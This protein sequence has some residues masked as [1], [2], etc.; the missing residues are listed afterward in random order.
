MTHICK[1]KRYLYIP[2]LCMFLFLTSCA[3]D[4]EEGW[5]Y[6]D[7]LVSADVEISEAVK[8]PEALPESECQDY[9]IMLYKDEVLQWEISL[10]E[11]KADPAN[12]Y[13]RVPAG[14]YL[15][16]VESC[17]AEEAEEGF[18][19]PRY[20]GEK[21][22]TVT[23]GR[24]TVETIVCS[25]VNAKV[26]LAYA[27]DFTQ[28]YMPW[29]LSVA[30]SKGRKIALDMEKMSTSHDNAQVMYYN[31]TDRGVTELMYTIVATDISAD[32]VMRYDVDFTVQASMWNKVNMTASEIT[33]Q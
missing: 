30:D 6:L 24:T 22:F 13:K 4:V 16:C 12:R 7:F 17:N 1:M 21:D 19:V 2:V 20:A 15:I 11:F 23:A 8:S 29:G 28:K 32:K 9:T 14:E 25:M 3:K 18:G 27:A 33:G 5:G 26:T 31:V 10:A